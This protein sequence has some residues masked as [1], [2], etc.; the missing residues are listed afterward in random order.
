MLVSKLGY[1]DISGSSMLPI[2]QAKGALVPEAAIVITYNPWPPDCATLP[3]SSTSR[4]ESSSPETIVDVMTRLETEEFLNFRLVSHWYKD[5]SANLFATTTSLATLIEISNHPTIGPAVKSLVV[6]RHHA[7][8]SFLG[9]FK[10]DKDNENYARYLEDQQKLRASGK[11]AEMLM[12]ALT[13]FINCKS[14]YIGGYRYRPWGGVLEGPRGA[15]E[16]LQFQETP[17]ESV[18]FVR[19][20]IRITLDAV[21]G[22]N[23]QFEKLSILSWEMSL[24]PA[25]LIPRP[26]SH[27]TV[28]SLSLGFKS[29]SCSDHS[30]SD[31]VEFISL[32]PNLEKLSLYFGMLR[33]SQPLFSQISTNL[34]LRYIRRLKI[35]G[36]RGNETDF[37]NIFLRHN[38]TLEHIELNDV[39]CE[40]SWVR[41]I[42][43]MRDLR[44][45]KSW[46]I[47][48]AFLSPGAIRYIKS[49]SDPKALTD[50]AIRELILNNVYDPDNEFG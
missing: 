29:A 14:V 48:D 43:A 50:D 49:P 26:D 35:H 40:G 7:I 19:R 5:T 22:I 36:V 18:E 2:S 47:A 23:R 41:V 28:K 8:E 39:E 12:S 37:T 31:I 44:S 3:C 27:L 32:F 20:A 30:S 33:I 46:Q 24:E 38:D 45:L 9:E 11:D 15:L 13:N 25:M 42:G 34:H 17:P 16:H 1:W 4:H 21:M 10:S 6:C